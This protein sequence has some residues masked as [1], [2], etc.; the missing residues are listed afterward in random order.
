MAAAASARAMQVE[1]AKR[2]TR[3]GGSVLGARWGRPGTS[4]YFPRPGHDRRGGYR[5]LYRGAHRRDD[6]DDLPDRLDGVGRRAAG[7]RRRRR[8]AR[9][10]VAEA[11]AGAE[12][13]GGVGSFRLGCGSSRGGVR[14]PAQALGSAGCS[15]RRRLPAGG[16]PVPRRPPS[17]GGVGSRQLTGSSV[18]LVRPSSRSASSTPPFRTNSTPSDVSAGAS[19]SVPPWLSPPRRTI[20]PEGPRASKASRSSPRRPRGRARRRAVRPTPEAGAKDRWL[21]RAESGA[22]RRRRRGVAHTTPPESGAQIGCR[23]AAVMPQRR[24]FLQ[25]K[26]RSLPAERPT[27]DG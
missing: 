18:G 20:D 12:V 22:G 25:A 5:S 15:P 3:R 10:G 26:R 19:A 2:R 7:R 23:R 13:A 16:L 21:Q 24:D 1:T 4:V 6:R 8:S 27:P 11:E 17:I 9:A 14:V